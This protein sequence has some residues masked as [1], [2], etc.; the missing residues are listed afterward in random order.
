MSSLAIP[1]PMTI[2]EFDRL[3]PAEDFDYEL[4]EGELLHVS[5]PSF[6]HMLVRER[7]RDLIRN[8][9]PGRITASEFPYQITSNLLATKRCADV[10]STTQ[11][12]A[13]EATRTRRFTGA[14]DLVVEIISPSNSHSKIKR[15][16]RLCMANGCQEFWAV[17]PE[18][19]SV[20]VWTAGSKVI[21][22]YSLGDT[23]PA[24]ALGIGPV[25]VDDI[26]EGI[27]D[28]QTAAGL[29]DL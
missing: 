8:S 2:E 26:F 23:I 7:V 1:R 21:T 9:A 3:E 25:R 18:D 5:H 10:A 6:V 16:R 22:P 14:P 20:D 24:N 13:A 28:D 17:D 29:A 11:E 27:I 4:L 19:R 12:R 15:L